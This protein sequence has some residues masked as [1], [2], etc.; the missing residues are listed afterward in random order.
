MMV[1]K[2]IRINAR[3]TRLCNRG[4]H[5]QAP[6]R[7][8]LGLD[9]THI[10][11][12]IYLVLACL[13]GG[14][15][16]EPVLWPQQEWWGGNEEQF[17]I[18]GHPE[19]K[20]S[21]FYRRPESKMTGFC[22][23]WNWWAITN[24]TLEVPFI[25]KTL[26]LLSFNWRLMQGLSGAKNETLRREGGTT[27]SSR[28]QKACHKVQRLEVKGASRVGNRSL[29]LRPIPLPAPS[30][31]LKARP[32]PNSEVLPATI[33]LTALQ[34]A[35]VEGK[36]AEH[37]EGQEIE[38]F[39]RLWELATWRHVRPKQNG[40]AIPSRGA[41]APSGLPTKHALE[42][43]RRVTCVT[44]WRAQAYWTGLSLRRLRKL[45]PG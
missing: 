26:K 42:P 39:R 3:L 30:K 34:I 36:K 40:R 24:L 25:T 33:V 32:P 18:S 44:S 29:S 2:T 22:R 7:Q 28:G 20:M 1:R 35:P 41:S 43:M 16:P 14:P 21:G 23:I 27:R 10:G 6:D 11:Q 37:A 15:R 17:S 12:G 4:Q 31:S 5:F 19:G 38:V 8:S 45:R 9:R 13:A